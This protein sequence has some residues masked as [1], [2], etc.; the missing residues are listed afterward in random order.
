MLLFFQ[1][2]LYA[3]NMKAI[4]SVG[5]RMFSFI[6]ETEIMT[7]MSEGFHK[8][9]YKCSTFKKSHQFKHVSLI[10][11]NLLFISLSYFDK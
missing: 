6:Q 4:E 3:R 2:T 5:K 8:S 1:Y 11:F 10:L 9:C 7:C